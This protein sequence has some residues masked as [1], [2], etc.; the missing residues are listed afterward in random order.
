MK[1]AF[2]RECAT[3]AVIG[4]G[5]RDNGLA[6]PAAGGACYSKAASFCR[7]CERIAAIGGAGSQCR[8]PVNISAVGGTAPP[9]LNSHLIRAA[10]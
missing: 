6:V 7:G 5:P 4:F 10:G 3:P 1:S 8:A 9:R 2:R